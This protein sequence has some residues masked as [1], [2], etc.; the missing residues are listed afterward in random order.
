[1]KFDTL[2]IMNKIYLA[3]A[4]SAVS[5]SLV[6]QSISDTVST[7]VFGIDGR[8]KTVKEMTYYCADRNGEIVIVSFAEKKD[9][10]NKIA[11]YKTNHTYIFDTK[12]RM[13][14]KEE[15][16]S[17]KTPCIKTIVNYDGS[18][19]TQIVSTYYFSD[20]GT[21][22]AKEVFNYD[23]KGFLTQE[24]HYSI[25]GNLTTRIVYAYDSYGN[26]TSK[27]EYDGNG[28]LGDYVIITYKY[29]KDGAIEYKQEKQHD[30]LVGNN[31]YTYYYDVEGRIIRERHDWDNSTIRNYYHSYDD[32]NR[33]V[34]SLD[35]YT[36]ETTI[37][38]TV[39]YTYDS[40][41]Q[42][43]SVKHIYSWWTQINYLEDG[44]WVENSYK[45]GK[46]ELVKKYKGNRL[47]LVIADGDT[48]TYEYKDDHR[49]NWV[50]VVE[51]KNTVPTLLKKRTITY[52]N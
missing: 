1:M 44:V 13:I 47:V 15:Y 37:I 25:W 20:I 45:S 34:E 32:S 3:I 40:L 41:G 18:R 26:M 27:K 21:K 36:D 16:S 24:S 49:G 10:A 8:I 39:S 4:L 48:Y 30:N 46:L 42:L 29:S 7:K 38:G 35:K 9:F 33:L 43:V 11:D 12:G 23:T 19:V 51:R 17:P 28:D 2:L 50:Q 14:S 22:T 6:A 31:V 5:I 52:Y